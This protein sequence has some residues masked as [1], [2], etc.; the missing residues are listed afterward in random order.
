LHLTQ[1]IYTSIN[2]KIHAYKSNNIFYFSLNFPSMRLLSET[3]AYKRN[4]FGI[5]LLNIIAQ[6]VS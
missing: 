2:I 1:Y 4:Q 6:E 3:L 5:I